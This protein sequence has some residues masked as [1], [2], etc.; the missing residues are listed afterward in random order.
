MR[1]FA[2]MAHYTAKEDLLHTAPRLGALEAQ[3]GCTKSSPC[4]TRIMVKSLLYQ[5]K[6]HAVIKAHSSS[7]NK[8]PSCR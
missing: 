1:G 3:M 6:A 7:W 2:L 8:D 5:Y 4:C